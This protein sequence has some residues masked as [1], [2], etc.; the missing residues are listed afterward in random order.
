MRQRGP[1]THTSE[2]PRPPRARHLDDFDL[3][4]PRIIRRLKR[5]LS[6]VR[7][8]E[9]LA[10]R[11]MQLSSSLFIAAFGLGI[12]AFFVLLVLRLETRGL[13][14][15]VLG[16]G[17]LFF[18]L[19]LVWAALDESRKRLEGRI[20]SESAAHRALTGTAPEAWLDRVERGRDGE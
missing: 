7:T 9:R 2:V 6:F 17:L 16:A 20:A 15:L 18:V 12:P 5:R 4:R 14:F 19:G 8:L 11:A 1:R 3:A 10:E 13:F